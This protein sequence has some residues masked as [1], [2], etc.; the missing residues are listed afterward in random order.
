MDLIKIDRELNH[1]NKLV[2]PAYPNPINFEIEKD[3]VFRDKSYNPQFRYVPYN[4]TLIKAEKKLLKLKADNSIFGRLLNQRVKEFLAQVNMIKSF[5][6]NTLTANS[7]KMF[8]KPNYELIMHCTDLLKLDYEDTSIRHTTM[9]AIKKFV[10]ILRQYKLNYKVIEREMVVNANFDVAHKILYIN[11]NKKFTDNEIKRLIIHEIDTHIARS[12]YGKKQRY[13]LFVVGFPNY[14][15]TEEGLAVY[16]EE[17]SGFL[18]NDILKRYAGRMLAVDLAL[19]NS[20]SY[21]YNY[22]LEYFNKEEAFVLASRVKRGLSDTSKPGAYTKDY[23]YLA[24]Y[25]RIKD[26]VRRGGDLH[27][28]YVGKIGTEHVEL[29]DYI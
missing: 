19:K 22:L 17:R 27:K 28:L 18:T 7:T 10:D 26:F 8:G 9:S 2:K 25:Y 21:V 11:K 6:S 4:S 29:L 3:K 15:I 1:I 5:G 14:L 16:N 24:G 12:E 20:F 13:K 23:F